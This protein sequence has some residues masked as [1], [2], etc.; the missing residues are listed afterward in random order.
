M[1]VTVGTFNLNNLF[2]RYNFRGEIQAIRASETDV[3]TDVHYEFGDA[4]TYKIRTYMGR[5]VNEKDEEDTRTI[6]DRIIDIDVDVLAVQEVEDIDTLKQFN[7]DYLNRMYRYTGLIE[8]NDP[9]L[10]DVGILSKYPIGGMTSWRHAVHPDDAATPVFGRDLHEVEIYSHTRSRK[11][12]TIF[13]NHLKSHFVDFRENEEEGERDNTAR[14][15]RQAEMIA[16]IV[17]YRTR[18]RSAYIILGDMN[19]PPDSAALSAFVNDP[20]LKLVDG[21][22]NP[23]ETRP[24]KADTPPPDTT[25]WTHRYKPTGLPAE[26]ELYDQIWLSPNLAQ[27]QTEAWIDRRTLHGGDGSDHDPAWVELRL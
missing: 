12:F 13:N 11:L 26:Y 20:N 27:K 9:R 2:S 6:A 21:L 14:R 25:A 24:P 3:E 10:I 23:Q 8:G 19:D 1:Y 22:A 18:P 7:R 16:E 4:D 17:K 5:L 15:T